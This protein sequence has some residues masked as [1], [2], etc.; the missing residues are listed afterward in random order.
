MQTIT[1]Q[2]EVLRF[3][4]CSLLIWYQRYHHFQSEG[5]QLAVRW[6]EQAGNRNIR[7]AGWSVDSNQS[8]YAHTNRQKKLQGIWKHGRASRL[9]WHVFGSKRSQ[10]LTSDIEGSP[11][12]LFTLLWLPMY[13][14]PVIG[15]VFQRQQL[16]M[17]VVLE[18]EHR[19]K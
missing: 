10:A 5:S 9:A 16:A 19:N 13:L 4:V 11:P 1:K 8:L 3:G 7:H 14:P 2:H 15:T 18:I 12:L 6:I 17:L